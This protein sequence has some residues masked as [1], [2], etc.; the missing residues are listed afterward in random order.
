[1]FDKVWTATPSSDEEK[2]QV[3]LMGTTLKTLGILSVIAAAIVGYQVGGRNDEM[4]VLGSHYEESFTW[5]SAIYIWL[6]GLLSGILF[7]SIGI[8]IDYAKEILRRISQQERG[9]SSLEIGNSKADLSKLR[10]FKI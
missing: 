2:L 5:S 7:Y 6:S 8:L 1:M 9:D 4:A 10:G 3:S